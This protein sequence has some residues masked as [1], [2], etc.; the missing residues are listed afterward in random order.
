MT[1]AY[2]I[3]MSLAGFL[4]DD[5]LGSSLNSAEVATKDPQVAMLPNLRVVDSAA[6]RLRVAIDSLDHAEAL[7]ALHEMG[8]FSLCPSPNN[9]LL[10]LERITAGVMGRPRLVFLGDLSLFAVRLGHIRRAGEYAEQARSLAPIAWE[11]YNIC[12]V[13]GLVALDAGLVPDAV[14][15]LRESIKACQADAHAS[16]ICGS[17]APNFLLVEALLERGEHHEVIRHLTDCKRVWQIP[18]LR[19][20]E[21]IN[22]I[23]DGESPEL[24]SSEI[25]R[26]MSRPWYALEAQCRQLDFLGVDVG[27]VVT[28]SNAKSPDEVAA[29]RA[30]LVEEY[31]RHL[32][33]VVAEKIRYLDAF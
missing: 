14:R 15:L 24:H 7:E 6:Q 3:R 5:G 1:S 26:A 12:V 27:A 8:V 21:W 23:E 19:F 2:D 18:Q 32:D 16:L 11:L 30:Q 17:R 22:Q 20:D 9:Q 10:T 13:E 25:V 29:E 33:S 31:M 4:N 28:D